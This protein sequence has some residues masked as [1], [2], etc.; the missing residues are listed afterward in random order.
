MSPR[1]GNYSLRLTTL[2]PAHFR[3]RSQIQAVPRASDQ[4]YM[5]LPMTPS[6]GMINLLVSHRTHRNILLTRLLG[7][8]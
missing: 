7:L 3:H 1:A 2:P 6:L 8:L 4:L 5:E